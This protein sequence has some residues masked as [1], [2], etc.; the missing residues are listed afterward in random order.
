[1][2]FYQKDQKPLKKALT[3]FDSAR[4]ADA[5]NEKR[6]LAQGQ[7]YSDLKSSSSSSRLLSSAPST[8]SDD[9]VDTYSPSVTVMVTD[10]AGKKEEKAQEKGIK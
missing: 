8:T 3:D 2:V 6:P 5:P 9:T 1:L 4:K 7:K 10:T